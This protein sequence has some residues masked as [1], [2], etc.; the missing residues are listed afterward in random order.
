MVLT[1][2]DILVPHVE[3]GCGCMRQ[4]ISWKQ[5]QIYVQNEKTIMIK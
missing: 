4:E 1:N 3:R 5:G 2:D